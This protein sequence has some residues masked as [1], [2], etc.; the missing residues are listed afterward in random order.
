[1]KARK[2]RSSRKR[3][4]SLIRFVLKV[5]VL[6]FVA[7]I[8]YLFFVVD[9]PKLRTTIP[10]K[11]AFMKLREMQWERAGK[12]RT[13]KKKYVPLKRISRHV[14]R[15]VVLSED[16]KFWNH[17]GFD[18]EAIRNA[19]EE[20]I[21]ARRFKFGGST[22]S[23]QLSR[24]LYLTPDKN[25]YRKFREA[26]ITWRIERTLPKARILEIYLNVVEWGDGVFGIEAAS[27]HY[28]G[29]PASALTGREASL[30]VAV[31]PNPRRFSPVRPGGY[32]KR[33]AHVIYRYIS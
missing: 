19:F 26:I 31:L 14:R 10:P 28:Y 27:R 18:Y 22:I 32:I 33:R 3:K 29:K 5:L 4:L 11:T 8:C 23:M 20:N 21:E 17:E 24:N 13:L 12:R 15:A 16:A 25:P 6:L 2:K 9:I 30:L 7:D 1:M